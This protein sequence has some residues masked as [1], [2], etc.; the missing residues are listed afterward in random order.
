MIFLSAAMD[1][2]VTEIIF[3]ISLQADHNK[4]LIINDL[5]K[6]VGIKDGDLYVIYIIFNVN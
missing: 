6:R 3:Q 1:K 2:T 4:D 5:L